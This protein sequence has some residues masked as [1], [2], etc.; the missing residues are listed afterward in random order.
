MFT[1]KNII[2]A[3]VLIGLIII[4]AIPFAGIVHLVFDDVGHCLENG[5]VWDYDTRTCRKDCLT[6]RKEFGGCIHLT[7]EQVK[8]MDNC[9]YDTAPCLSDEDYLEICEVNHKAW[10]LDTKDCR[11]EFKPAECGKLSGNWQYPDICR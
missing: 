10:N 3:I 11:F 4:L 5:G 2:K 1:F 7:P 9:Q 8:K 6:W